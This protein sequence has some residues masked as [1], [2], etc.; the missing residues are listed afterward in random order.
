MCYRR[1]W[2]VGENCVA[3][4]KFVISGFYSSRAGARLLHTLTQGGPDPPKFFRGGGGVL[5]TPGG[6]LSQISN[7]KIIIFLMI[8]LLLFGIFIV[9]CFIE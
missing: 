6:S 2:A 3:A 9:C 4:M 5:S 7:L 1:M 8:L